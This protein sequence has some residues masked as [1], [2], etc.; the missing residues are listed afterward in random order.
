MTCQNSESST[1]P[2]KETQAAEVVR[3]YY[4]AFGKL[5]EQQYPIN[6]E[7][8]SDRI[9]NLK[10]KQSYLSQD[11]WNY[12]KFLQRKGFILSHT[13][14]MIE[15]EPKLI[16]ILADMGRAFKDPTN[17]DIHPKLNA[18]AEEIPGK[19]SADL[20]RWKGFASFLIG[21]GIGTGIGLSLTV[22]LLSNAPHIAPAYVFPLLLAEMMAAT[23]PIIL[24]QLCM[25][26]EYR[27]ANY[28][29]SLQQIK[30]QIPSILK[31]ISLLS[32]KDNQRDKVENP[33]DQQFPEKPELL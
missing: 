19:E 1:E 20:H 16:Q 17:K 33:N 2:T 30:S 15:V 7:D 6:N 32:P 11:I 12:L 5:I 14:S 27:R 31:D 29:D 10:I 26:D 28:L 22:I 21:T 3:L 4:E 25:A 9:N 18:L 8:E 24:G 13:K 23:L